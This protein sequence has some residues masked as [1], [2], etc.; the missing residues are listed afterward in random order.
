MR[1]VLIGFANALS[2]VQ[3]YIAVLSSIVTWL[4]R[5]LVWP[6][7]VAARFGAWSIRACTWLALMAIGLLIGGFLLFGLGYVI[8]YPWIAG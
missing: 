5:V 8:V 6:F 7:S 4:L 3:E 1:R 2:D